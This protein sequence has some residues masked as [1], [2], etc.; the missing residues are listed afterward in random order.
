MGR[1]RP[2]GG[3]TAADQAAVEKALER[4]EITDLAGRY[5]RAL[6]GG[7]R[8]RVLVA[9][10]LA[11]LSPAQAGS[12]P[13]DNGGSQAE[14]SQAE[15]LVLDEPTA[16]MDAESGTRLFDTL[17]KLK[18][19]VTVLIVTHDRD[20]VSALTDRVLCMGDDEARPFGI[21][22][23]RIEAESRETHGNRSSCGNYRSRVL[24]EDSFPPDDCYEDGEPR[25]GGEKP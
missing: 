17:G 18:G 8:R 13:A 1:L 9:R 21:V 15:I 4:A 25:G 16:N 12:S 2:G 19:S 23:H 11:S 10:A 3:Y 20:F 6:S 5:Y 24:H 22:Q 14:E 7:Q